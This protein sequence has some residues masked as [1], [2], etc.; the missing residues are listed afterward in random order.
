MNHTVKTDLIKS[1]KMYAV[2]VILEGIFLQN[3]GKG[4]TPS[5]SKY[6]ILKRYSANKI[7]IKSFTDWTEEDILTLIQNEDFREN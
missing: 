1:F 3:S 7:N 5:D 4:D 2:G 6:K